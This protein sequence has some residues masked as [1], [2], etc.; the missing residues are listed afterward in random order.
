L[1]AL[2][3]VLAQ[4]DA[5]VPAV[6]APATPVSALAGQAPAL[7]GQAPAL[8]GQAPVGQAGA[9]S[10]IYPRTPRERELCLQASRPDWLYL[11]ALVALDSVA[12]A[13]ASNGTVKYDEN[14]FL[15]YG[16]PFSVGLTWGATV[17]GAWL[18]LPQCSPSWVGEAPPEGRMRE[19][20]TLAMAFALLA[21][22]TAPVVN[23]IAIGSTLPASWT[24]EEREAHLFT[25][26]L[27]GFGGA[28]LPYL[29]PPRTWS[30]ARELE[31]LRL[32]VSASRGSP[33]AYVGYEVSF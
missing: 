25:A 31:K 27:A 6:V 16:A 30:A 12:I 2:A 8:A 19:T 11:G 26:A 32:G 4:S 13:F 29:L 7:A 15:R 21:G 1:H 20:W 33:R 9:P 14:I 17:G 23:G 18:A 24:T 22:V 28:L 5:N 3:A 10:D